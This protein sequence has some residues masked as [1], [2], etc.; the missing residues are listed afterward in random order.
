MAGRQQSPL[1]VR[2][3]VLVVELFLPHSCQLRHVGSG[4]LSCSRRDFVTYQLLKRL[5]LLMLLF[6]LL[7]S[8]DTTYIFLWKWCFEI[9]FFLIAVFGA[10]TK[11]L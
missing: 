8:S 7:L 6:M 10:L 2:G 4:T 9:F 5:L 11:Q 3:E 1:Q